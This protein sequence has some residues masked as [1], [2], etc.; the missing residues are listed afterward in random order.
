MKLDP[1]TLILVSVLTGLFLPFVLL[2]LNRAKE[3]DPAVVVWTRAVFVYAFGLVCLMLRNVIPDVISIGVGNALLLLG[4]AELYQGFR[5]FFGRTHNRSWQW[6][7]VVL[8][9]T[10]LLFLLEGPQYFEIRVVLASVFLAG[11][12]LFI[13]KELLAASN[14]IRMQMQESLNSDRYVLLGFGI[15]F[16]ANA[17]FLLVRGMVFLVTVVHGRVSSIN[18]LFYAL[19]YLIAIFIHVLL[20]AGLPLLL[21]RRTQRALISSEASLLR[22]QQVGRVAYSWFDTKTKVITLNPVLRE[23]L[24]FTPELQVTPEIWYSMIHPDD[25]DQMRNAA[26]MVQRGDFYSEDQEYRIFRYSDHREIWVAISSQVQRDPVDGHP[27]FLSILRDITSIKLSE[28]SA[29][30]KKN[31][32]DQSNQSK[33]QFLA[34]MSHEIRTPMNAILGMLNLLEAT[35]LTSRQRDYASKAE[36]AAK[37][38]LGLINDILDFSKV[39]AGKMQLERQPFSLEALMRNLAVVLSSSLKSKNIEVLF[40]MDPRLPDVIV[41]DTMR[42]QQVLIN[43]GSNA[44]K[45]TEA[46]QVVIGLQCL[47]TSEGQVTIAFSIQDTGIGIAPEHQRHIFEAFSQAEASTTRR[48]GGTGLGLAISK[49]LVELMGGSLQMDSTP[50]LGTTFRFQI[51]T[52]VPVEIPENLRTPD[53]SPIPLQRT[54]IVD[55]NPLAGQLF[56]KVMQSF[57]WQAEWVPSGEAAVAKVLSE[58]DSSGNAPPY[59]LIFVDWQMPAMDGWEATRQIRTI[60]RQRTGV[61][62]VI[63]MVS[64]NGRQDLALRSEEDQKL[65]DGFLVKPVSAPMILDAVAAAM[66]GQPDIR[67]ETIGRSSKRQLAGMRILVVED[68]LLNQQVAEELL[69]NE[70]A[71]VSL[72]ANGQL[73]V[74]AV[75][76]ASPQFDAVLMDIQM[77]VMDGYTATGVIR[78]QLGLTQLPIIA[79]TANA[80]AGD[81]EACIA[82]GMNEHI[83]KPFDV[84]MLISQLIRSTGFRT[85]ADSRLEQSRAVDVHRSPVPDI[86]GM[87]LSGAL[88][89]MSNSRSLF[90]RTARDFL[91][92]LPSLPMELQEQLKTDNRQNALMTLHTLKGIAG[93]LG[94]VALA[95]EANRLEQLCRAE[96]SQDQCLREIGSLE[97]SIDQTRLL[98]EEA[99]EQLNAEAVALA[100]VDASAKPADSAVLL[101]LLSELAALLEQSDM[102]SLQSFAECHQQL[103]CLPDGLCDKLS[104]ALQDLDFQAAHRTCVVCMDTL[105][106]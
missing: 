10:C 27:I 71:I 5:L 36:S 83:G 35:S 28:L 39:D 52:T 33:S 95:Y 99:V 90:T 53:K 49:H 92:T 31:E 22:V 89:R 86:A 104:A 97:S 17:L 34:N 73:G 60:A 12:S 78:K 87:D 21:S 69:T 72:A 88:V 74:D 25:V 68:N 43:L 65:V 98:L 4:Y 76:A 61:P 1:T 84:A 96:S 80:M 101:Q 42:L 56:L 16:G 75:H 70:G 45:F 103:E 32:A 18:D 58:C 79:M 66:S 81:R 63:I 77:P 6:P 51:T 94:V 26:P 38:L 19:S 62:P 55:D 91:K 93:T 82:S 29:I 47:S 8:Y 13:A 9:L 15:A 41:G 14:R 106:K 59:S 30:R 3:S 54:L 50:G 37:S 7:L 102:Q 40:D 100:P 67:R 57:G 48:Y 64:A 24:G 105:R 85:L 23:M 2:G 46:G 20:A 11:A 44:I